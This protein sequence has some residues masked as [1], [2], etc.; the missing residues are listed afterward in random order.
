MALSNSNIWSVHV[1]ALQVKVWVWWL[2]DPWLSCLQGDLRSNNWWRTLLECKRGRNFHDT[3][4]MALKKDGAIVGQ[5]PQEFSIMLARRCQ[6][7]TRWVVAD[8]TLQTY[9][10]YF[11]G[12]WR[13]PAFYRHPK[14]EVANKKRLKIELL[15]PPSSSESHS[16]RSSAVSQLSK[17]KIEPAHTDDESQISAW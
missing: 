14:L 8:D 17:I 9:L 7:T 6:F 2:Q 5:C 1:E 13:Y 4:A 16:A 10:V 3:F 15:L 11:K 12:A